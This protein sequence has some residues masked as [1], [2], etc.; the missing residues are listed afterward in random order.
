MNDLSW[1][2]YE[3]YDNLFVT[4]LAKT[5]PGA[6]PHLFDREENEQRVRKVVCATTGLRP[7]DWATLS[8]PERV[9]WM[10][11]AAAKL[12]DNEPK[13]SSEEQAEP[14]KEETAKPVTTAVQ[15]PTRRRPGPRANAEKDSATIVVAALTKHHGYENGSV[16]HYTPATNPGLAEKYGLANNALTR[17]LSDK[18]GVS[19]YKQACTSEKIG[20]LLKVWNREVSTHV[21]E[22]DERR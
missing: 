5:N 6:L 13:D 11:D 19:G 8:P 9:P 16:G 22:F 18:G 2:T 12:P 21:I 7:Q 15:K 20:V 4:I 3:P 14:T 10:E 17:F 1:G